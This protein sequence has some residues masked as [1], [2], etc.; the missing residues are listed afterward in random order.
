MVGAASATAAVIMVLGYWRFGTSLATRIFAAVIPLLLVISLV[1]YWVSWQGTTWSVIAIAATFAIAVIFPALSWM[2]SSVVN[3]LAHL[4][5]LLGASSAQIA[6]TARQSAAT[7]SEQ[8]STVAQLSSTVEELLRTSAATAAAAQRVVGAATDSSAR[9][10]EGLVASGRAMK[11]LEVVGQVIEIAEAIGDFAD[12]SNLLAV[13][14]GIEAAKAGEHGRGFAVV[15]AEVRSLAE[16]SKRAASRIR[17]AVAGA[18]DGRR[19]LE[20]ANGVLERLAA[21]LDESADQV[22]QIAAT[23]SQEEAGVRQITQAIAA[24]AEGGHANAAAASQLESAVEEV[25]KVSGLL[26]QFLES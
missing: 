5:G 14:A 17:G 25:T 19:A 12:Q 3:R 4:V 24:V 7:A 16:Q 21:T 9:G 2:H 15:A 20:S 1:G 10:Q 11:V 26:K 22:R 18:E 8:A 6:A 23:A 13:N